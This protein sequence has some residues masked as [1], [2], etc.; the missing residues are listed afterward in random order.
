MVE[1]HPF[2]SVTGRPPSDMQVRERSASGG[3]AMHFGDAVKSALV[4]YATFSGR[5]RRSEYWY[6]VLFGF[7]LSIVASIVDTAI[8]HSADEHG[9]GPVSAIVSIA[10]LLPS[11][12][13][14]ARRLHD[15]DRSGWW[16]L[17]VFVPLIGFLVLIYWA[18]RRGSEGDNRFGPSPL[19]TAVPDEPAAPA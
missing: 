11:L 7:I 6:F 4:K 14:G 8:L 5:A 9:A 16:L 17:I 13:V 18:C 3:G 1:V 2:Y 10:L 12:A 19:A 15:I